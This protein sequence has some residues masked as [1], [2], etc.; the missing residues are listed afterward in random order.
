MAKFNESLFTSN[1]I[2]DKSDYL[3][4]DEDLLVISVGIYIL[5]VGF[6]IFAIYKV[7]AD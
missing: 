7:L 1:W 6:A 2:N 3:I 5:T 4:I